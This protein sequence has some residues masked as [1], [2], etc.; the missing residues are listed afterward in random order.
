GFSFLIDF[1]LGHNL[2]SGLEHNLYRHGLDPRT[3]EGRDSGT[4]VLDGVAPNGEVNQQE[5]D[6]YQLYTGYGSLR[7]QF[8][9]NAGY[10][11]LRQVTIDYNLTSL[12]ND[13]LPIQNL[14]LSLI[15]NH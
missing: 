1:K 4:L 7:E 15:G 8:I 5:V 13:F 6:V 9:H 2:L 11:K 14:Q 3:L 10:W 12:V